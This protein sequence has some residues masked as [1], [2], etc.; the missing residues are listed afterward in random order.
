MHE[1]IWISSAIRRLSAVVITESQRC[2]CAE[3][4]HGGK[5]GK[6]F[7]SPSEK[8]ERRYKQLFTEVLQS[9]R[10]V[11]RCQTKQNVIASCLQG[12]YIYV[13]D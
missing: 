10:F 5:S 6:V 9:G 2:E 7:G 11:A 13:A 4:L 12:V 3:Q 1:L 8:S